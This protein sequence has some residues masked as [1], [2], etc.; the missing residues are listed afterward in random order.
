M[1]GSEQKEMSMAA[2]FELLPILRRLLDSPYEE[3]VVHRE[4]SN[5]WGF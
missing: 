1:A 4:K 5:F 3:Y 2:C